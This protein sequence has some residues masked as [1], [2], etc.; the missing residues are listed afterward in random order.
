MKI[1]QV[2]P[3]YE[4][5]PPLLYGG[6]ER[7]V[8]HLVEELTQRGHAV[9]LF[10]SGVSET[11]ARLISPVERALRLG[12]EPRDAIAAHMVELS[13]VFER[14]SE[15]D[16]I[17]CHVDY[18]AFPF[19]R[20]VST[21]TVHTMHGRLDL[22]HVAPLLRHFH[23]VP[24]ISISEAQRRPVADLSLDWVG[25]V[26]HG[27]PLKQYPVGHGDG[28]YLA[29]LGRLSPEKRPDLA[30]AVAKRL[31]LRLRIAAKVDDVDREYFE[32]EIEPLLNHPLIEYLGEIGNDAKADFL[33]DALALIF[34]VDWP[35]PFGL[36][37]IEALACGT[38]VI[39][40]SCGSI[41]EVIA[42]G[43]TGVIG[44]TLDELVEAARHVDRIDRMACRQ[45]VECRFSVQSM[46]DG[47]E[48]IYGKLATR[49]EVR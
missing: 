9:T 30:I 4:P 33:G 25:T 6:T 26:Y 38:P 17:H 41:P 49:A 2:A 37:M 35:E 36:A 11:A 21:P 24:L 1:A 39:S 7:V 42:P 19:A 47:Y 8:S 27:V 5:V 16:M 46:A 10:A 28:G 31:G 22:P 32:H 3:L 18:L 48:A 13:H 43:R 12:D 45:E 23:D 44:D 15:F 20:L 34:P 40:R 29:F 14:A